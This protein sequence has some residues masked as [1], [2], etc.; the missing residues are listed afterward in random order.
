MG[1][2]KKVD[3]DSLRT[4][5]REQR[6]RLLIESV[7]ECGGTPESLNGDEFRRRLAEVQQVSRHTS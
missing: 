6:L 2:R 5:P 4:M 3:L 1:P 7:A